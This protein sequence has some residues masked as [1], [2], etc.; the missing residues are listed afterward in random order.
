MS[1]ASIGAAKR[2]DLLIWT[3]ISSALP[4]IGCGDEPGAGAAP[5]LVMPS[6]APPQ[7]IAGAPAPAVSNGAAAGSAGAGI[8]GAAPL[9]P[10]AGMAGVAPEHDHG[11]AAD[12]GAAGADDPLAQCRLHASLDAR[13]AM[14]TDEPMMVSAGFE[15]DVLLP[16]LVLDWMD[17]YQFAEAHDGW[18]L[19]R[20]WDQTCRMSNATTCAASGALTRQG[21]HRAPIQQGAPGDGIA[22]MMMHR[23][24]IMMLKTAFP[25]HAAL[26]SGFTTVP[27]SKADPENPHPWHDIR[28]TSNNLRGFD[29]LEH[30]EDHLE[31]FPT[32]D[33]LGQFIENTYRW[34][35]ES[36][37]SPV[38]APG[39]GLHGAL[40]SQWAVNGSPANLIQQSVDVKNFAFWKLHGWIDDVWD[41]YR[42]AK[43]LS[44]DDPAYQQLM[45][46]QCNEMF[47]LEPR[48]RDM[49]QA[50]NGTTGPVTTS[51]ET[52]EF[53]T[54]V[55]PFL[56]STCA[57]CHGPIAPTA[58][59]TLGG[60]GVSSAD[61]IAGLVGMKASNGEYN[62]IEPGVPDESW[63]YLKASGGVAS[64]SCTRPCDRESMPPSGAGLTQ[65]Q[66][67]SL[68]AW[69][70]NGATN[71]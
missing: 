41:R 68:R 54:Q 10:T 18:H 16:Q 19:V 33:D 64:V 67:S 36:P 2:A 38:N 69:I 6:V 11:A 29:I 56:D 61:V 37:M 57:G 40:H 25:N 58:G 5:P 9:M 27:K 30:I 17:E 44:D 8:A 43:G 21:L 3:L 35:P 22:F 52:G 13:D 63:V 60:S 51:P 7:A 65:A 50:G 70:M 62:L 15:Q 66:L 71:Q 39:S 12:G 14:L 1:V 31:Q 47:A 42:K 20:K 53:A 55:R 26:F 4:A 32:D 45:L 59:M 24:M 34:T 48:N 28:W 49:S 46:E 23:H